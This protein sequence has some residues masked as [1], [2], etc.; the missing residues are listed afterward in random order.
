[1]AYRPFDPNFIGVPEQATASDESTSSFFPMNFGESNFL[2]DAPWGDPLLTPQTETALPMDYGLGGSGI[3][4]METGTDGSQYASDMDR[5]APLELHLSGGETFVGPVT[6]EPHMP[7]LNNSDSMPAEM[8]DSPCTTDRQYLSVT[9]MTPMEEQG[10]YCPSP[11]LSYQP[12][13]VAT[14]VISEASSI[15]EDTIIEDNVPNANSYGLAVRHTNTLSEPEEG[16]NLV[17]GRI[18]HQ[19]G[20]LPQAK[21]GKP[22][23]QCDRSRG[24]RVAVQYRLPSYCQTMEEY[25]KKSSLEEDGGYY[26]MESLMQV[27]RTLEQLHSKLRSGHGAFSNISSIRMRVSSRTRDLLTV[28]IPE[29]SKLAKAMELKDCVP[30]EQ[31]VSNGMLSDIKSLGEL[32]STLLP[33]LRERHIHVSEK[34][35]LS[36]ENACTMCQ[37][38]TSRGDM[39]KIAQALNSKKRLCTLHMKFPPELHGMCTLDIVCYE[40]ENIYEV[41]N[42]SWMRGKT[43]ESFGCKLLYEDSRWSV[44]K[45]NEVY[46]PVCKTRL[47]WSSVPGSY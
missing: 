19:L 7:G 9:P 17:H 21:I 33:Y 25:I 47:T 6:V 8:S 40:G 30:D 13:S 46:F 23:V 37:R 16:S 29:L 18:K 35:L 45:D 36:L 10:T 3:F 39:A 44:G 38:A 12:P 14:S 1:M 24:E 34:L 26:C 15:A 20:P 43:V 27:V 28:L 5:R 4:E 32:L 31:F 2:M 42:R 22:E 11:A 41:L